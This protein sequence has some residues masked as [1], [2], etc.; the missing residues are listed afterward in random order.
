M[1]TPVY[2]KKMTWT[3]EEGLISRWL[4]RE[5]DKI[6]EG[7]GLCE[8]E[9]EKTTDEIQAPASGTLLRILHKEGTAVPVNALIAVIGS[10]G[11]DISS[12][13]ASAESPVV[14]GPQAAL[15]EK[16]QQAGVSPAISE[17]SEPSLERVRISPSARR[18]ARERGVDVTKI[19]GTGPS[20]RI[21][22]EDV[23]AFSGKPEA[24]P[25]AEEYRSAPLAGHR[26]VIADRLS[27]SARTAVHVP[28]TMEI[29]MT[30]VARLKSEKERSG[31]QISYNDFIIRATAMALR[32]FPAV[33]TMLLGQ[34]LRTISEVNVGF[35]VVSGD[36]LLV[37]VIRDVDHLSLENIS[38]TTKT[39]AERARSGSLTTREMSGGT[40]TVSNLGMYDVDFFAPI[41]N[42]PETA[43]LGVGRIVPRLVV[44]GE[45]MAIR[46]TMTL[47]LVFDH[48]VVDGVRAARF[49][50]KVKQLLE[51]P[52]KLSS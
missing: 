13:P 14:A 22:S 23:L 20:G 30:P 33:N 2:L 36:D 5:G 10:P 34:E 1:A 24:I 47:T 46:Q 21:V 48:R 31:L 39:L 11:E 52:V 44:V 28:I 29:D 43:I 38:R 40:F 18:L 7:E 37:P 51:D 50:Q 42:P 17:N 4:K 16:A 25:F 12:V 19:K 26:K 6:S 9:T 27:L 35:A 15:L 8:V 41:I 45:N 32:E 49:L 3:M